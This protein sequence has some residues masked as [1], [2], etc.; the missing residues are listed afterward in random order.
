MALDLAIYGYDTDIGKLV[1][2]TLEE[3]KID[4]GKLYP[5]SP[6]E[7]E[8]DAVAL[9]ERNYM[10][11]PV[12]SF[13]FSKA[14]VAMFLC[15]PDESKRLC[16]IATEAGCIVIDNSRR[17]SGDDKVPLVLPELNP[18]A[19]KDALERKVVIPPASVSAELALSLSVL[20]DEFGVA[21]AQVTALESVSEHGRAGTETLARETTLLLNGM[22]LEDNDFPAQ[23]AFNIH[24]RIGDLSESGYSTHEEVVLHEVKR[25]LGDFERGFDFT[26][27]QVPVFY[28]HTAVIHVELEED[29]PVGAVED[30]FNACKWIKVADKDELLTPVTHGINETKLLI[31]RLHADP[32]SRRAFDFIVLMDNARRGEAYSCVQI[33]N[34]LGKELNLIGND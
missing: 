23:L 5:L 14:Q 1:I 20:H 17:F 33:A 32:S 19:V 15:P 6:L 34:L 22:A 25:L 9:N 2:E 10:I 18:Y 13:D 11:E 31:T 24:T 16:G 26:S 29:V 28:G 27:I 8:F 4:I 30:A 3:L 12:S 21:R 7:G